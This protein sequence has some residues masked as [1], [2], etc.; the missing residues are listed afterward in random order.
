M[1]S[2]ILEDL[3]VNNTPIGI[4][5][6]SG[7]VGLVSFLTEAKTP[8]SAAC[9]QQ[10]LNNT[11]LNLNQLSSWLIF[12]ESIY[13]RNRI[14]LC[15]E[16]E[17]LVMCWRSGQ[18]TP[19]HNHRGSA[20]AVKVISGTASEIVYE[21]AAC[22]ALAPVSLARIFEGQVVSSFDDDMHQLGNLESIGND[23]VTVHCY[24]PPLADY[25]IFNEQSTIFADYEGLYKKA[26]KRSV[27][28][29]TSI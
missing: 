21:R 22:N 12:D 7:V 1:S 9:L 3:G 23:L 13:A 4:N 10:L 28:A 29:N 18:M 11:E 25:E 15:T 20:C 17:L 8:L 24:S 6:L 26:S 19:I 16:A 14:V 27:V 5:G 2:S